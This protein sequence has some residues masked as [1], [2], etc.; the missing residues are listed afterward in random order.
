MA[1]YLLRLHFGWFTSN[2]QS[3]KQFE[4]IDLEIEIIQPFLEQGVLK[5]FFGIKRSINEPGRWLREI[6]LGVEI[7]RRRNLIF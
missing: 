1:Y 3:N 4:L 7:K 5:G 2:G 6:S